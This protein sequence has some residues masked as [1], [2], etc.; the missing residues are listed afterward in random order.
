MKR[1]SVKKAASD[2]M[3]KDIEIETGTTAY[4]VLRAINLD[5]SQH[6]VGLSDGTILRGN[7]SLYSKVEDGDKILI[8]EQAT[9]GIKHAA[10]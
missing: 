9:V 6:S 5:P 4:D 1:I 2:E 7:D 10:G 3:P 8:T